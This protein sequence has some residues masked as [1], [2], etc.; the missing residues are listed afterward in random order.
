V[1][2]VFI[3]I[4]YF[5]ESVN[6][7]IFMGVPRFFQFIQKYFPDTI[8]HV[9]I[10]KQVNFQVDNFY[11]DSNGLIHTA[12]R[13]VFFPPK[14]SKYN[15]RLAKKT[16]INKKNPGIEDVFN[17]V[18]TTI[19]KL[20]QLVRPQQLLFVA[21]D[22]SA[23][24]AKQS[25]QRQRR[26]VSAQ[27]TTDDVL[28]VFDKNVITPGT[29]FMERLSESLIKFFKRKTQ[30]DPLW[31]SLQVQFTD[32]NEAGEGEH[33]I[34]NYIRKLTN[35]NSIRHCMYGLDAD[36]FMLSL[37]THCPHFYLLREDIM[38]PDI[39]NCYYYTADIGLL[40]EQL[41]M[42]WDI[43]MGN[44]NRFV[45][46][47]IFLCFFIGNDFLHHIPMFHDLLW[48]IPYLL[49]IRKEVIAGDYITTVDGNGFNLKKLLK[50][51]KRIENAEAN[52]LMDLS[53]DNTFSYPAINTSI[54]NGKL[55]MSIFK[56]LYYKK[57]KITNVNEW[58]R[59]YIQGL[60][61]VNYYYHNEPTNWQ[62]LFPYHYT[63]L[64]SDLVEFLSGTVKIKKMSNIHTDPIDPY[65][66]LLCVLPRKSHHA[67]PE[68]LRTIVNYPDISTF[69]PDT[70][71]VDIEGK[72]R[73][74]QGTALIPFLDYSIIHTY[75][76]EIL[77]NHPELTKKNTK[78]KKL[79]INGTYT[80][81]E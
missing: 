61:W 31:K 19:D 17:H 40:H 60:E 32:S 55:D 25:Q 68:L 22:G 5:I 18:A 50:I 30:T 35:K 71:S 46:D 74:W 66:Q 59:D 15:P 38:T 62:W 1:C 51:L 78:S 24:M 43:E 37:T 47:F 49:D 54:K 4:D 16:K 56:P 34:I 3:K 6:K 29:E 41:F 39:H 77:K 10:H 13:E 52:A 65:E 12:V 58:C 33:K 42:K 27:N 48:S 63:P 53:Y 70:F 57:T 81:T 23:P 67:I 44:T 73:E 9:N 36:L 11:I 64:V 72:S 28:A 75:Y 76:L 79:I 80:K 14:E 21:I 2:L 20:V 26:F 8:N 45:N 7:V 69:Y